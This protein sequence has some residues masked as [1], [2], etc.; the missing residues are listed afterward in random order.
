MIK[1]EL[2]AHTHECDPYANLCGKE[3]VRALYNAGYS[4]TVITDHYFRPFL[5]WFKDELSGCSKAEIIKRRLAGYYA[6]KEEGEKLGFVVLPGAEVRFDGTINDYLL[7]G[8]DEE[9]F[10]NAP[11]LNELSGIDE[12]KEQINDD[13]L[14]VFAHPFR[15]KMTVCDPAPFFGIEVYNAGTEAYRNEM[16]QGFATHY[17]KVHTSGS[18]IHSINAVGKGGIATECAISTPKELV[19][20]LK[21]GN[22]RLIKN[23][24]II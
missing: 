10:Y 5:D 17:G 22:F 2:H 24:E 20:V 3:L 12:L 4:G 19:S 13:M 16:A 7:L 9:F 1:F 11:Y 23:G 18:D 6:A 8:A 14:L 15:N 21:S